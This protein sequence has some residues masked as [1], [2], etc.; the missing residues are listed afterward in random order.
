[1]IRPEC[2]GKDERGQLSLDSAVLPGGRVPER[3]GLRVF[4]LPFCDPLG[5]IGQKAFGQGRDGLVQLADFGDEV[6]QLAVPDFLQDAAEGAIFA[7]GIE[8]VP[9]NG[10]HSLQ[11]IT[12]LDGPRVDA[13]RSSWR[14]CHV[15]PS[16]GA[17]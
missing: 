17:G 8:R 11:V 2:A 15:S 14:T 12:R 9:V 1:M 10:D 13:L 16:S 4:R 3:V 6:R 7:L 5:V